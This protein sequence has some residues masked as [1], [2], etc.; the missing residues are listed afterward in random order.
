MLGEETGL[1]VENTVIPVIEGME[2]I[3]V[4]LEEVVS[5]VGIIVFLGEMMIGTEIE[6][7]EDHGDSLDQE[8][9]V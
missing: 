5:E 2:E 6:M 3:E 9:E 8:K 1:I 7:I 4:I